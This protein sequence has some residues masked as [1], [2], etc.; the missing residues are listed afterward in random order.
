MLK[1]G[2]IEGKIYGK[3]WLFSPKYK[4]GSVNPILGCLITDHI[5]LSLLV[6]AAFTCSR[7][8]DVVACFGWGPIVVRFILSCVVDIFGF[9]AI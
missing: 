2:L 7:V 5:L 8:T 6:L 4:G 3:P 9:L 1:N